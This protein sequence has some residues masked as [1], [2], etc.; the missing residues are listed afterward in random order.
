MRGRSM[1]VPREEAFSFHV[2][3]AAPFF[4]SLW[5]AG[6]RRDVPDLGPGD[7]QLIDLRDNPVVR[8]DTPFDS[9]RFYVPQT[10]P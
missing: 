9:L 5:T 8:L 6:R 4:T 7:A 3:L 2:P 1:S 10:R